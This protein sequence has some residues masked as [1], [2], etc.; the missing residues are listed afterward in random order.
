[1]VWNLDSVWPVGSVEGDCI[2]ALRMGGTSGETVLVVVG[3][4]G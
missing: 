1:M 4:K 2:E 3:R